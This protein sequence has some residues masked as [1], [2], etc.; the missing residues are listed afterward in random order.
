MSTIEILISFVTDDTNELYC[1]PSVANIFIQSPLFE[2][3]LPTSTIPIRTANIDSTIA[4]SNQRPI[5]IPKTPLA[6]IATR[7]VF[8]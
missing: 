8:Y 3:E 1:E 6:K 4:T 5:Q 2:D 7:K